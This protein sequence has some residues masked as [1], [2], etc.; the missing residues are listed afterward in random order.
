VLFLLGV[1]AGSNERA[2]AD[3]LVMHHAG[4]HV[5]RRVTRLGSATL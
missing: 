3:A 1:P 5:R 2:E 4:A